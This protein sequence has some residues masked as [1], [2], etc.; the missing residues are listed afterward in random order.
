MY[1]DYFVYILYIIFN[2]VL[3]YNI[4][5][6]VTLQ[7]VNST[8]VTTVHYFRLATS[9]DSLLIYS[10]FYYGQ[11]GSASGLKHLYVMYNG[12]LK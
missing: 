7:T 4:Y 11:Y 9:E 2:I 3:P 6:Q 12:G 5:K 8:P 10:S 1:Y